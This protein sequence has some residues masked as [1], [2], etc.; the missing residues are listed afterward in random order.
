MKPLGLFD[1]VVAAF[2]PADPE[3]DPGPIVVS[4]PQPQEDPVPTIPI[5]D[6]FRTRPPN[7]ALDTTFRL[8]VQAVANL[9]VVHL[10]C[11]GKH[12][13]CQPND[14]KILAEFEAQAE[15]VSL[16]L[17]TFARAIDANVADGDAKAAAINALIG[18]RGLV[19]DVAAIRGGPAWSR[20]ATEA[21][22]G[23]CIRAYAIAQAAARAPAPVSS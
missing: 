1:R 14:P 10:A 20:T 15:A 7:E 6:L 8:T 19:F 3:P 13:G 11:V 5:A 17:E 18:A 23:D 12:P 22:T 4:E 21:A 9:H 2:R 16:K